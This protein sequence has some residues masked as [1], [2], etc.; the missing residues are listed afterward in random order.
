MPQMSPLGWAWVSLFVV[1][2]YL[3]YLVV[4]Y[5]FY[6]ASFKLDKGSVGG[7]AWFWEW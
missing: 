7:G 6:F 4:F 1:S 5:F 2:V 3:F